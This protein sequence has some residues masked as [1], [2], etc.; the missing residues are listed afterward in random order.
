MIKNME[1]I[2]DLIQRANEQIK[3]NTVYSNYELQYI[4]SRNSKITDIIYADDTNVIN[5]NFI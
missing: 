1:E 2:K 4:L 3:N 5:L